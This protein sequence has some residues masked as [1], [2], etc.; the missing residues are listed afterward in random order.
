M[1]PRNHRYWG[2]RLLVS[3]SR[4]V[5]DSAYHRYGELMTPRIVESGSQ[6]LCVSVIRGVAIGKK[7]SLALI[8]STL[9]G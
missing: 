1:T 7:I 4:R 2:R 6:R 3:L 9:N 8:F 5:A